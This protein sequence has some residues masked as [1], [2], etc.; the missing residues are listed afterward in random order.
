MDTIKYTCK[1][2]SYST[3]EFADLDIARIIK[4]SNRTSLPTR[5]YKCKKCNTWH[6]TKNGSQIVL[7][8][9]N[10]ILTKENELLKL[11]NKKLKAKSSKPTEKP[12][13]D[14]MSRTISKMEKVAKLRCIK[15]KELTLENKKL[16]RRNHQMNQKLF[17]ILS[18]PSNFNQKTLEEKMDFLSCFEPIK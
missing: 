16:K 15:N 4:H 8:E 1:K 14:V 7:R 17:A 12:R 6:L 5:S 11:E 2:V 3:K 9:I 13:T 18:D 10:L